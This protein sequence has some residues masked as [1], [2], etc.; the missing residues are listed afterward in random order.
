MPALPPA[1]HSP[2]ALTP[3]AREDGPLGSFERPVYFVSDLHLFARRSRGESAHERLR[4]LASAASHI[5][6]GGDIFDFRWSVLGGSDDTALAACRWLESL[7]ESRP[8]CRFEYVLGNHDACP[9]FRDA[10][11]D[12]V[13]RCA[14][15]RVHESGLHLGRAFFTHG[16]CVLARRGEPRP[17]ALP[18]VLHRAYDVAVHARLHRTLS[19]VAHPRRRTLR[20]LHRFVESHPTASEIDHVYFGHTHRPLRGAEF[21]GRRYYNG[22]AAVQGCEFEILEARVA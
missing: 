20:Q 7:G 17:R 3:S 2:G 5:V 8:D 21:R 1:P 18:A 15:L 12:S 22:G 13:A 19:L 9:V 11:V 6:L 16:D 10:L 14:N 4:T